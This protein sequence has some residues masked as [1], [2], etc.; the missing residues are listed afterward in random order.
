MSLK[1]P[2]FLCPGLGSNVSVCAGPPA[3]H[4]RMHARFGFPAFAVSAAS[5]P[6]HPD[7]D[8]LAVSCRKPRRA[9]IILGVLM[10][11]L[12]RSACGL[13]TGVLRRKSWSAHR[14]DGNGPNRGGWRVWN[15]TKPTMEL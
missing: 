3:I 2:P 9:G 13:E 8:M 1:G 6:S 15:E 7:I 11:S 10:D 14:A 4:S 12:L 5:R